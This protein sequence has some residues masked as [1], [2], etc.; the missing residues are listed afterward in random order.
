MTST[1]DATPTTED[2]NRPLRNLGNLVL[3]VAAAMAGGALA[4]SP[5][6]NLWWRGGLTAI[7][8]IGGSYL[9]WRAGRVSTTKRGPAAH[10]P[11]PLAGKETD[12]PG[13]PADDSPGMPKMPP[14][15]QRSPS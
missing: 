15:L 7:V 1:D 4:A 11:A 14:L 10:V 6:L 9:R 2:V 8:A 3:A 5:E 12:L 13:D